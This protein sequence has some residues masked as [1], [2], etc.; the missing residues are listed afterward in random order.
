MI[1]MQRENLAIEIYQKN[2]E[3]R[4]SSSPDH[5]ICFSRTCCQKPLENTVHSERACWGGKGGKE[6][7]FTA[8]CMVT[9]TKSQS[10]SHF[11]RDRKIDLKF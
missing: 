1:T 4:T 3:G 8:S 9:T 11:D 5:R 6:K 10:Q 7:D 2:K